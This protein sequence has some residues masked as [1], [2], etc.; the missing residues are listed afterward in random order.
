ML[1][2]EI[3]RNVAENNIPINNFATY[4][5]EMSP[6]LIRRKGKLRSPKTTYKLTPYG[7]AKARELI[8]IMCGNKN[9]R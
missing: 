5:N 6:S 2:K 4:I 9:G 7:E 3:K 1:A 8:Q